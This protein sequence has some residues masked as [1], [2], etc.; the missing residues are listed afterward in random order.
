MPQAETHFKNYLSKGFNA[1]M[2]YLENHLEKR[3]NPQLLLDGAE[4][5]VSLALNY[6][7]K[8]KLS[9]RG[10]AFARYA[11]GK[12]YHIVLKERLEQLLYLLKSIYPELEG[13]AFCDT[14]PILEKYW[15]VQSGI[16]WQGKNTQIII[17]NAGSYFFLGELLLTL[18]A[19]EYDNPMEPHCGNCSRCLEVCPSGAL[20]ADGS[21]LD[22]RRCLSYLTIE[23]RGEIP[24]EAAMKM[25]NCIYGCDR[26]LEACPH[27]KFA[28]PTDVEDFRPSAEFRE[29]EK[30]AW[31]E[32]SIESYRRIFSKSAVKRAKYEGLLRNI[33]AAQNDI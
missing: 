14:A 15:A 3:M 12:D 32:L 16:G 1:E 21:G 22:A 25:D 31:N 19:S 13:R 7:P 6:Y 8:E 2:L 9:P 24:K 33:R 29:M 18:K 23:Q 10:F 20:S 4:T 30:T 17:P 26:C 5:M 28:T 27:N 11:Y